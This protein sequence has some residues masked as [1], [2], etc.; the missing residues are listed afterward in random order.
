M[1]K[2]LFKSFS[3]LF[4]VS[5]V[6][7]LA[8]VFFLFA[9]GILNAEKADSI[10]K[11]V[12]GEYKEKERVVEKPI[13]QEWIKLQQSI[14][15]KEETFKLK[16]TEI[17]MLISINSAKLLEIERREK[18]LNQKEAKLKLE[19]ERELK[20]LNDQKEAYKKQLEDER[21]KSNIKLFAKMEAQ[22]VF[23]LLERMPDDE[24]ALYLRQLKPSQSAEIIALFA[25]DAA[26]KTR[27]DKILK[28]P[29]P[30]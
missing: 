6:L 11:I 15:D 5:F 16:E 27:M 20:A 18:E 3:V 7:L 17:N 23:S 14:N 1:I 19:Y 2:K 4:S 28:L 9:S 29:A 30:N 22:Q 12:S 13:M 21:F 26:L 10:L 25:R 24:V 8:T